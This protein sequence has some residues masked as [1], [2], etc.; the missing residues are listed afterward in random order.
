M[1]GSRNGESAFITSSTGL[2]RYSRA[3]EQ[4]RAKSLC[5]HTAMHALFVYWYNFGHMHEALRGIRQ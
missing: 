1:R 5:H 2:C 3:V 4:N